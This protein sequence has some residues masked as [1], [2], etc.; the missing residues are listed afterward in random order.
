MAKMTYHSPNLLPDTRPYN[1]SERLSIKEWFEQLFCKHI[2][3][4]VLDMPN[5]GPD[6]QFIW[7]PYEVE[8]CSKCAKARW[9]LNHPRSHPPRY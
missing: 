9:T 1:Y 8:C 7:G 5:H 3:K 2:W 6:E 4:L